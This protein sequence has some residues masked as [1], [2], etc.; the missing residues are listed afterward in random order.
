MSEA[1]SST[2]QCL[3]GQIELTIHNVEPHVDACH[4]GMCRKWG[5]SPLLGMSCHKL[6]I[7]GPEHMT[8][9]DSSEWAQRTFCKHCG[10]HLFYKIKG[11]EHYFVTSGFFEKLTNLHFKEEIFIDEKPDFYDFANNTKKLTAQQTIEKYAG[12]N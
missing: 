10:T 3:C 12:D 8:I 9:Y 11:Q 1:V 5:G 7:K 2:S 4:C 6:D